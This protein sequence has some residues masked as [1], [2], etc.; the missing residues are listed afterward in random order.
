[1]TL[2]V[3]TARRRAMCGFVADDV[4]VKTLTEAQRRQL[5]AHLKERRRELGRRIKALDRAIKEFAKSTR[6]KRSKV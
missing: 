3:T 4:D 6:G 5:E 1:V 2:H